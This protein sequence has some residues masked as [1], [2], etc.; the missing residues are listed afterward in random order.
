MI[1]IVKNSP[2]GFICKML[3]AIKMINDRCKTFK[4]TDI[5]GIEWGVTVF[6]LGPNDDTVIK[7]S[8]HKSPVLGDFINIVSIVSIV[9][10]MTSSSNE[11]TFHANKEHYAK[12]FE[13]LFN[14]EFDALVENLDEKEYHAGY[15]RLLLDFL[16]KEYEKVRADAEITLWK[17]S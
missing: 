12:Y 17:K 10:M 4:A 6:T 3:D 14:R 16:P 9:G 5:H 1:D 2:K 13:P 7:I 15:A 8:E 11:R